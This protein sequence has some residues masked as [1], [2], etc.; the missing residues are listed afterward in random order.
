[1]RQL[2]GFECG[3]GEEMEVWRE[4]NTR[5]VIAVYIYTRVHYPKFSGT[6]H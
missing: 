4:V 3:T 2:E 1:M 6:G 5:R